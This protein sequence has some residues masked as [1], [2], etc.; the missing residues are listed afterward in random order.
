[1]I[2]KRQ[3][4]VPVG[5]TNLSGADFGFSKYIFLEKKVAGDIILVVYTSKHLVN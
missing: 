5:Q 1:L 3:C 2:Q 4:Q